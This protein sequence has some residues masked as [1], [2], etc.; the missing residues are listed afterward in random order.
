MVISALQEFDVY[1]EAS[2]IRDNTWTQIKYFKLI[3]IEPN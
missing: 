2:K 3:M 1:K